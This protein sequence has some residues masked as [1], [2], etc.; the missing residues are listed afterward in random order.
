MLHTPYAI[1]STN[2]RLVLILL[3]RNAIPHRLEGVDSSAH[4]SLIIRLAKGYSAAWLIDWIIRI[5]RFSTLELELKMM[6][7]SLDP[8]E[9]HV[10]V[11]LMCNHIYGKT[12]PQTLSHPLR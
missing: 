7:T 6:L 4:Y 9:A 10:L 3:G 8:S 11:T 2:S 12:S 1:P 5:F